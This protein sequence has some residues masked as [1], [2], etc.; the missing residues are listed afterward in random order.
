ML[1]YRVVLCRYYI[2]EELVDGWMDGFTT[3]IDRLIDRLI[4]RLMG[5]VGFLFVY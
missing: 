1:L 5:L 3:F 2:G 4:G